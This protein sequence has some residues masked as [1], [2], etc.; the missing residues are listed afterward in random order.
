MSIAK[1]TDE[2]KKVGKFGMVGIAATGVHMLVFSVLLEL[3]T[4]AA[5]AAN[6]YAFASAV[7][8]SF[9]G[10]RHWSFAHSAEERTPINFSALK[11]C[12]VGLSGFAF[13]GLSAWLIVDRWMMPYGLALMPM[14]LVTPVLTYLAIRLWV[15]KK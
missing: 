9:F 12:A 14:I 15:T 10:N 3:T 7:A 13:N 6:T 5:L 1:L 4:L 11:Y 2:C 8:F